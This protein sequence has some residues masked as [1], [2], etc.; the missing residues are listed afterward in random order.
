MLLHKDGTPL[1]TF[2]AVNSHKLLT[3]TFAMQLSLVS[4][5]NFALLPSF[6]V[7]PSVPLSLCLSPLPSCPYLALALLSALLQNCV[8]ISNPFRLLV[9]TRPCCRRSRSYITKGLPC[10]SESQTSAVWH[11][12]VQFSSP[13]VLPHNHFCSEQWH[14]VYAKKI[15]SVLIFVVLLC[16]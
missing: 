13:I 3:A 2:L 14:T 8:L 5:H 4:R 11:A 16:H 1:K 10:A 7:C 12:V 6:S 15:C 9:Q